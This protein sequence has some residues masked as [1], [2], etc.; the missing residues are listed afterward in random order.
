MLPSAP[1][2]LDV[3]VV[4]S[5]AYCPRPEAANGAS[6][7][8]PSSAGCRFSSRFGPLQV[9]EKYADQRGRA[10]GRDEPRVAANAV[11][12]VAARPAIELFCRIARSIGIGPF[13][14]PEVV[15]RA[16]FGDQ[17]SVRSIAAS[18]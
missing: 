6:P 4:G 16:K 15:R 13:L 10:D 1:L 18:H 17:E 2:A 7:A 12:A 11:M 5:G 9:Q 8:A 14:D 3:S